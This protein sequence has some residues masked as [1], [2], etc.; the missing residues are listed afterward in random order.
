MKER[1]GRVMYSQVDLRRFL[2]ELCRVK[3]SEV[4]P[5]LSDVESSRV[6]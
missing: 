3:Y 6:K 1:P 2:V 5:W 4:E